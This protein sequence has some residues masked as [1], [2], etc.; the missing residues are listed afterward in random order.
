MDLSELTIS[1]AQ[2]AFARG[3]WT[4]VRLC[5]AYLQRIAAIDRAGPMLRLRVR[6][7]HARAAHATV[8]GDD[9]GIARAGRARTGGQSRL[10]GGPIRLFVNF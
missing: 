3:A 8:Q 6:A 4:S 7:G 9:A 2:A 1:E 5:E 10:R